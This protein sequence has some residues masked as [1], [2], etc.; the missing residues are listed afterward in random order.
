MLGFG[1]RASL[2]APVQLVREL[3]VLVV[4]A[5]V[6]GPRLAGFY[7][8]AS[9]LFSLQLSISHAVQRVALTT[10]ARGEDDDE[11]DRQG[12]R[13]VVVTTLLAAASIAVIVAS[14]HVLVPVVFGSRWSPTVG[15]VAGAAPGWLLISGVSSVLMSLALARGD[16]HRSL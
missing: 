14:A 5:V 11:R 15:V 4:L 12:A 3:L 7:N 1:L 13:A 16:A 2:L 8:L 6:G 9:R 10:F